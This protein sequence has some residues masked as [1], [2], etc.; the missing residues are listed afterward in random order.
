MSKYST[1]LK[2]V[3]NATA[4]TALTLA[5]LTPA[6]MLGGSAK[7]AQLTSRSI[8]MSN[9]LKSGSSTYT[10]QFTASNGAADEVVI[11]FCSDSPLIGTACGTPT[12]L[13]LSSATAAGWTKDGASTATT[14]VLTKGSGIGAGSETITISN[15]TNPSTVATFY[16]RILTY[17]S[18]AASYSAETPGAHADDGG[19]AMSTTEDLLI[20]ARVQEQLTFCV[21][22]ADATAID[23]INSCDYLAGTVDLGVVGT[24]AVTSPRTTAVGG[25][26]MNGY[27]LVATN[28][29]NGVDVS[30]TSPSKLKVNGANCDGSFTDQCFE[31]SVSADIGNASEKFGMRILAIHNNGSEDTKNLEA[32]ADYG[33]VNWDGAAWTSPTAD[34]HWDSSAEDLV[35]SSKA[36]TVKVVDTEVAELEFKIA[37]KVTTPTGSYATTANFVATSSF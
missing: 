31:N 17:E 10:V 37:S 29:V 15:V 26:N 19:V 2:R 27:F 33:G 32:E 24:G 20:N 28:A 30:Y 35:A 6:V 25:N 18:G 3:S 14:L 22:A 7:A 12:G 11:D 4:A 5:S 21:G 13:S 8:D 36:N 23:S 9:S 34:Y 1:L 16:A